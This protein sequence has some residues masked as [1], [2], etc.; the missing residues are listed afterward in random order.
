MRALVTGATGMLGSHVV[1]RL[2]AEGTEVRALVR[3]PSRATWLARQN[4]DLARGDLLDPISLRAAA[5]GCDEVY[6]AAAVI[7]AGGDWE[8]FRRGNVHGTRALAEAAG[9]AGAPM[10]HVSSTA[11]FGRHRFFPHPTDETCPLPE[12]PAEDAYG[13]SKQEA[14]RVVLEAHARG[15]MHGVVVRPP[16]MYGLRDRQ[17]IPRLGTVLSR[18]ILP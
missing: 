18:S 16:V 12:L 9:E 11:V 13:R 8:T 14:E 7:G 1:E 10:V 2:L 17:F 4:V 3:E 15:T 5:R 6:H